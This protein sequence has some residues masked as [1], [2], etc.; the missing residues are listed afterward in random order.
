MADVFIEDYSDDDEESDLS[1]FVDDDDDDDDDAYI[2]SYDDWNDA[3]VAS[4]GLTGEQTMAAHPNKQVRQ[5]ESPQLAP[6]SVL[7]KTVE[8]RHTIYPYLF[9][10]FIS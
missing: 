8:L 7:A 5:F 6:N 3:S 1:D 4:H 9:L 10:V 2:D